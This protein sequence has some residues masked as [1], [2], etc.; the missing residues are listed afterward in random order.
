MSRTVRPPG[1]AFTP[2]IL[3]EDP[4][5]SEDAEGNTGRRKGGKVR[6]GGVQVRIRPIRIRSPPLCPSHLPAFLWSPPLCPLQKGGGGGGAPATLP[7][8]R[9][10]LIAARR[11]WPVSPPVRR[12]SAM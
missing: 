3:D 6:T 11:P 1:V 7:P 5:G 12:C 8:R 2:R 4:Q 9:R 10:C